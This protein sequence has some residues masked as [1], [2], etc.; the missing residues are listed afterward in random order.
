MSQNQSISIS[1]SN[2]KQILPGLSRRRLFQLAGGLTAATLA[3]GMA[4]NASAEPHALTADESNATALTDS[5][6]RRQRAYDLRVQAAQRHQQA[7]AVEHPVNGDEELYAKPIACF[8]K[9]LPHNALGEVRR[10][11]YATLRDALDGKAAFTDIPMGGSIKLANPQAAFA[12]QLEGADPHNLTMP[13]PPTFASEETAGEMVELYWQALTRDI[14]FTHYGNEP[15]TAAAITDLQ[16]FTNFATVN[17]DSLFRSDMPGD[18]VGPYL[19]QFLYLPVP[20]GAMLIDQRYRVPVAGDDHQ[21]N[22]LDWLALQAGNDPN[23]G[24]TL[25]ETP[26]YLRNGRDLGEWDHKDFTYQGFLNAALILN[27]FGRSALD[28]ANPYKTTPNQGGFVTLGAPD[29][30]SLVANLACLALKAAWV[31]K[32]L[33]HRRLRPEV[34]GGRVH[35][36]LT[37]AARYPIHEKLFGAQVLERIAQQY[38]G[39]LLPLAYPEGA[40]THPAYPAGHATIAGACVTVLKAFYNEEFTLPNPQVAADDGLAL[41]PYTGYANLTV[42]GELNKLAANVALGRDAAGVHWRSD[43]IEGLR[44]GET[45]AIHVM[46]DLALT[47]HEAFAGFS[48]TRFDGSTITIGAIA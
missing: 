1:T 33:F 40:P 42:G 35:N 47:Y 17:P 8:S 9:G 23:R 22:Y 7:P 44:L 37:E 4:G 48:L 19:S 27:S 18:L 24:N 28:E 45:V 21:T 15:L 32:W 38:G 13:P 30:L 5:G 11:A 10:E 20:Y 26:R 12:Y 16:A 3:T 39:Y 6:D 25:D 36:H 29:I 41:L 2:Q 34:F 14:P 31:Q 43:S 46:E